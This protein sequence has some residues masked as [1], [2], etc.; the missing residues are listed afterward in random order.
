MTNTTQRPRASLYND[1]LNAIQ[2]RNA[3]FAELDDLIER[4]VARRKELAA[5][6]KGLGPNDWRYTG[7]GAEIADLTA[8]IAA[9]LGVDEEN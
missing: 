8:A 4:L 9:A 7:R 3:Q 5:K 1:S 2:M 6:V